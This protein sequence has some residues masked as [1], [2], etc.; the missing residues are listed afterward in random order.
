MV[1]DWECMGGIKECEEKETESSTQLISLQSLKN[2]LL[3]RIPYS[4]VKHIKIDYL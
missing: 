1:D 2:S 4:P 3:I